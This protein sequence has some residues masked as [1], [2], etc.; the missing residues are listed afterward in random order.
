MK[1]RNGFV[2]NSSSSSFIVKGFVVESNKLDDKK[3]A[4]LILENFPEIKTKIEQYEQKCGPVEDYETQREVFYELMN[5][6]YYLAD[7]QEDGAPKGCTVLGQL[8]EDTGESDYI[9]DMVIDCTI[10]DK[11]N[12]LK[13]ILSMSLEEPNDLT[14]KII[15]GTRC[16]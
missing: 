5:L 1:I 10:D 9:H 12:K 11:L 15:C 4:K 13:E 6:G 16:C 2:S 14:I 8:L 7:T 3:L